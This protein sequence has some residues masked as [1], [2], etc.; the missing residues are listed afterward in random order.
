MVTLVREQ[1]QALEEALE[2]ASQLVSLKLAGLAAAGGK[3]GFDGASGGA[4]TVDVTV[5]GLK[6]AGDSEYVS[7][8]E[9]DDNGVLVHVSRYALRHI[10]CLSAPARRS[11]VWA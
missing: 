2:E 9:E 11:G 4:A 5:D 1:V 7:F 10:A 6:L 3:G 8:D